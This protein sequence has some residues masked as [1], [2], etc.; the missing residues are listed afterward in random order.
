M[1]TR[2]FIVINYFIYLNNKGVK[3]RMNELI[4]SL[5]LAVHLLNELN[6]SSLYDKTHWNQHQ[7]NGTGEIIITTRQF[8]CSYTKKNNQ[9]WGIE[10]FFL[11]FFFNPLF[12]LQR[13]RKK[14]RKEER[15]RG[16]YT[17]NKRDDP[18]RKPQ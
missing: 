2:P 5:S 4:A 14:G 1:A 6:R 15:K 7:G 17:A 11:Y 16:S 12:D 3:Y 9:L 13:E 10:I 18:N 8:L